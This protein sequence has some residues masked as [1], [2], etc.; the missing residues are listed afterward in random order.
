MWNN[1]DVIL[2]YDETL[3]Y[4]TDKIASAENTDANITGYAQP[5]TKTPLQARK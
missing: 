2:L 1:F 3:M 4:N 5:D